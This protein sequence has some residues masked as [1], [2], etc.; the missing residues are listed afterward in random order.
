MARVTGRTNTRLRP[1]RH[2]STSH[3]GDPEGA[4]RTAKDGPWPADVAVGSSQ[5]AAGMSSSI[6][7][8]RWSLTGRGGHPGAAGPMTRPG[9]CAECDRVAGSGPNGEGTA[10]SVSGPPRREATSSTVEAMFRSPQQAGAPPGEV[11]SRSARSWRRCG[12]V[13]GQAG[14]RYRARARPDLEGAHQG[15]ARFPAAGRGTAPVQKHRWVEA[16]SLGGGH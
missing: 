8:A 9:R 7:R 16:G 1:A 15:T 14:G 4:R 5:E 3:N 6:T 13:G 11:A 12:L 2:P 10:A